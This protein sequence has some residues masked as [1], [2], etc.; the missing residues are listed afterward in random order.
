[1]ASVLRPFKCRSELLPESWQSFA[2]LFITFFC[3][4]NSDQSDSPSEPTKS[5]LR[6]HGKLITFFRWELSSISII[7]SQFSGASFC[8]GLLVE[9]WRSAGSCAKESLDATSEST[10]SILA[11]KVQLLQIELLRFLWSQLSPCISISKVFWDFDPF[12]NALQWDIFENI[13]NSET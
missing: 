10:Y 11:M 8:P 4:R 1:M 13:W 2:F 5:V 9:S 7:S 6:K 3:R 12:F